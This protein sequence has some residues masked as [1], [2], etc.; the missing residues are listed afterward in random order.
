MVFHRGEKECV[1]D[2]RDEVRDLNE[3]RMVR[4]K[5]PGA[6]LADYECVDLSCA[7]QVEKVAFLVYVERDGLRK[8]FVQ[9]R[10]G[11]CKRQNA[12]AFSR[13]LAE[14]CD[15]EDVFVV[16]NDGHEGRPAFIISLGEFNVV[17]V[18]LIRHQHAARDVDLA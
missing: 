16:R 9:L 12:D 4:E 6:R 17:D 2:A 11:E 7:E 3:L 14:P 8:L 10:R 18:P 1:V 5:F 15:A 13:Q